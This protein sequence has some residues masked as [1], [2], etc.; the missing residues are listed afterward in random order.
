MSLQAHVAELERRHQALEKELRE[1]MTRPSSNDVRV[2]DLKR[3]K[4]HL[5]DEI[6]RLKGATLH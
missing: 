1:E 6:S 3:R 5:K 2:A 4:L